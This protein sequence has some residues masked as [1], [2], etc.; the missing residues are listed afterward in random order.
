[1]QALPVLRKN[2]VLR[3]K[4]VRPA[5]KIS[6]VPGSRTCGVLIRR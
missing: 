2:A 4:A 6:T 1:M 5:Q 3:K